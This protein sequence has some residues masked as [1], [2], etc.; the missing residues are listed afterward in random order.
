MEAEECLLDWMESSGNFDRYRSA[1]VT[2]KGRKRTHGNTKVGRSQEVAKYLESKGFKKTDQQVRSKIDLF[3][4]RWKLAHK[5]QTA[6]G[7]G[8]DLNETDDKGS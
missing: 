2:L 6:T 5:A 7:F 1:A 8:V 3:I 4:N